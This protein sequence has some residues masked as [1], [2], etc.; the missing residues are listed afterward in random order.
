MLFNYPFMQ[1]NTFFDSVGDD[2]EFQEVLEL[3]KHKQEVFKQKY[4]ERNQ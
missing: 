2:P 1:K 3:A 4:F